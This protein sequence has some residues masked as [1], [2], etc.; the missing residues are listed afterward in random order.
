MCLRTYFTELVSKILKPR[1][2]ET[3]FTRTLRKAL[4]NSLGVRCRWDSLPFRGVESTVLVWW[5]MYRL[6]PI[7]AGLRQADQVS[8]SQ[9]NKGSEHVCKGM[10]PARAEGF[11]AGL[12]SCCWLCDMSTYLCCPLQQG[13]RHRD[14][15]WKTCTFCLVA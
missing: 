2:R 3:V 13:D 10:K 4:E 15:L 8:T 7:P 6:H 9:G 5:W 12:C 11:R 1:G 14:G